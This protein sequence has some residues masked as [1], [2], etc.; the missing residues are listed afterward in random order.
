MTG[1]H[2][3]HDGHPSG[4][5]YKKTTVA[6]LLLLS[7]LCLTAG[8]VSA[9]LAG[10]VVGAASGGAAEGAAELIDAILQSGAR[11]SHLALAFA[12]GT[13]AFFLLRGLL[14]VFLLRKLKLVL[15]YPLMS[16]GY[17]LVLAVSFILFNEPLTPGKIAGALFLMT[18]VSLVSLGEVRQK[19]K[20]VA[21]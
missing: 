13:Y 6:A 15:V 10:T 11:A 7:Y 3:A 12:V 18:G 19:K 8:Q 17:I 5:P 20:E 14:W 21:E 4:R 16:L 2:D 9:K 1:T